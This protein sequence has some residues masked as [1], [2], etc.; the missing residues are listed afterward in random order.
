MTYLTILDD[1]AS[2]KGG[3][4]CYKIEGETG[5]LETLAAGLKAEGGVRYVDLADYGDEGVLKFEA[6]KDVV[7][8]LRKRLSAPK[9][10]QL[11][12]A[13]TTAADMGAGFDGFGKVWIMPA[14]D[15]SVHGVA[16]ELEGSPFKYAYFNA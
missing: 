16:P 5:R 2:T 15:S 1:G 14:G 6:R 11:V 3:F 4:H 8:S 13:H 12:D 10:R 9:R 7:T